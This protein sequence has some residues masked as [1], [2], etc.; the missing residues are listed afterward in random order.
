ML[1]II[2]PKKITYFLDLIR[3]D[4]PVGFML[5]LWPCWFALAYVPLNQIELIHWYIYFMIGAFLMRCAGCIIN[6]LIDINLDK[7]VERTALRPLTS[8]KNF[9][10]RGQF[11]VV[12][13]CIFFADNSFTIQH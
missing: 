9:Y 6:D 1:D 3:L 10:L 2:V 12:S 4:K 8:K 13:S 11:I 5:L 7:N